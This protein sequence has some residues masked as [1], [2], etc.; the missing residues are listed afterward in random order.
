MNLMY[1]IVNTY[2]EGGDFGR[3]MR[4]RLEIS[5]R[6]YSSSEHQRRHI[7]I[8]IFYIILIFVCV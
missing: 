1:K 2:N 5:S 4:E 8:F 7:L 6:W 3:K